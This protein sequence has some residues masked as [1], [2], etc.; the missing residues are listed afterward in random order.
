MAATAAQPYPGATF[1]KTVISTQ[2]GKSAS[3]QGKHAQ[4]ISYVWLEMYSRLSYVIL[5]VIWGLSAIS[6]LEVLDIPIWYCWQ[7]LVPGPAISTLFMLGTPNYA[8]HTPQHPWRPLLSLVYVGL[9]ALAGV[10]V[11]M[12]FIILKIVKVAN[13]APVPGTIRG[14]HVVV[15]VVLVCFCFALVV[16][17]GLFIW[18]VARLWFKRPQRAHQSRGDS[19]I[20]K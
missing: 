11:G 18:T 1:L 8:R 15:F 4:S 7:V 16:M 20:G 9:M 5:A 10:V 6:Y 3:R 19:G 12:V 17:D 13:M 14:G 2:T